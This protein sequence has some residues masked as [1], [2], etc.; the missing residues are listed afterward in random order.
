MVKFS[1]Y[2]F[3]S[4]LGSEQFTSHRGAESMQILMIMKNFDFLTDGDDFFMILG[5]KILEK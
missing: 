1:R 2:N 4:A 5:W 3:F